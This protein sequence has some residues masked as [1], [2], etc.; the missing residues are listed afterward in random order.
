MSVYFC[1]TSK[2]INQN[3]ITKAKKIM[4]M[5]R[6]FVAILS[7]LLITV[8]SL[9]ACKKDDQGP[10]NETKGYSKERLVGTYRV[11]ALST[12]VNGTTI[13]I[14]AQWDDCEKDN[15]QILKADMTYSAV[16]A[17]VK[18][19]DA[20]DDTGTWSING[21]KLVIDGE[22]FNIDNFEGN[23]LELSSNIPLQ[24]TTYP[25]KATYTKQ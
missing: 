17:G 14:L 21:S 11:T 22:E 24:N 5:K 1:C 16:D 9:T 6:Q 23:K 7:V 18:C 20:T 13:N 25:I 10:S 4:I 15:L 8:L 2:K 3:S 12:V 19:D